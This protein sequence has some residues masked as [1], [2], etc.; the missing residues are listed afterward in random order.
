MNSNQTKDKIR[1]VTLGALNQLLTDCTRCEGF[2][3][4]M[5]ST[6]GLRIMG[7][8]NDLHYFICKVI[9]VENNLKF[10]QIFLEDITENQCFKNIL[11]K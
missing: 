10:L 1:E 11:G 3:A 7:T 4:K 5:D 8:C 6:E 2:L 9:Y